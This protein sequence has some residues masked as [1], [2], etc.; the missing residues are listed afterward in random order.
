MDCWG[1]SKNLS[2]IGKYPFWSIN[3]T[4]AENGKRFRFKHDTCGDYSIGYSDS[5]GFSLSDAL[6]VSAAFPGGIGPLKIDARKFIW[7]KRK[8]WGDP[9]GSEV[10]VAP[11][12]ESL[13]IYDG[14]VYDNLGTEPLYDPGKGVTKHENITLIV[15]DAGSPFQ[16]GFSL[17]SLNPFRLKRILDI[18]MEQAR[19]LRVRSLMNYIEADKS[20]GSYLMIGQ[21]PRDVLNEAE[22]DG[23]DWQ[24]DEDVKCAALYPT[25][26]SRM[27]ITNFDRIAR[28]GYEMAKAVDIVKARSI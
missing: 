3:G 21:Y 5:S 27:T 16:N 20:H 24:S 11:P 6:A 23:S 13:H 1:I 28:H 7:K 14:G 15:S 8:N 17:G 12:Y 26:L 4:T 22:L 2:D 25:S 9:E 19:S 18:C 10:E